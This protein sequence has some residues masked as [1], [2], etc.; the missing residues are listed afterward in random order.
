MCNSKNTPTEHHGAAP[1]AGVA[2]DQSQ[3]GAAGARARA[4]EDAGSALPAPACGAAPALS[5]V[6]RGTGKE[7]LRQAGYVA[8]ACGAAPALSQVRG[9]T[10]E[11]VV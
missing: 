3:R 10:D 11:E 2:P 1:G 6:R 4:A 9:G 7:V 8:P 5:Q